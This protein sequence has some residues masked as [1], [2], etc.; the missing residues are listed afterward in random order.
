M[1]K[2]GDQI[3]IKWS[4]GTALDFTGLPEK[5]CLASSVVQIYSP[6][7]RSFFVLEKLHI[8]EAGELE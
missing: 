5:S 7:L 3:L 1:C 4:N 2:S 8:L 6:G